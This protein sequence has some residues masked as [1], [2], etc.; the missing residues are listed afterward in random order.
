MPSM[1]DQKDTV[2]ELQPLSREIWDR[3]YRLRN[4]DGVPQEESVDETFIR[5][6][7]EIASVEKE[8]QRQKWEQSFLWAL[9]N[10]AVPAGRIL[11]NAGSLDA[12]SERNASLINC[13]VSQS[14]PDNLDGIL[15]MVKRAGLTLKAGSGIGY[16]FSTVRPA[17]SIVRGNNASAFGPLTVM[18]LLDCLCA[19]ISTAGDRRGAQMAV[20]DIRHPDILSFIE[21]KHRHGRFQNFNMSVLVTDDFLK[22]LENQAV[23]D[24]VF[25]VKPERFLELCE[26]S[27]EEGDDSLCWE[28]F[29]DTGDVVKN[30]TGL[31]ACEK[32]DAVP[33]EELWDKIMQSTY[34][35]SEPGILFIDR[36][37]ARNNNSFCETI[38]ATNPCGE[39]PLPPD[40]ACLLGS[41][42]LVHFIEEPFT[43]S[44]AF[45]WDRFEQVVRIFVRLLDNVVDLSNLPLDAQAEEIFRKRRHGM[46][47]LGLGSAV[48]MLRMH[49]G[50]KHSL[51]FT[52]EVLRRMAL[53]GWQQAVEI[54]RE[55]GP[56]PIM[57]E[58]F[59]LDTEMLR[60]APRLQSRGLRTGDKVPG[61]VLFANTQ[62]HLSDLEQLDPE[63]LPQIEK[64]GARF[65][66]HTSIAPTG[67]IALSIGNN[68]SNGIEPS[69]EHRYTRRVLD[70]SLANR[71][72]HT[73]YSYEYL[74]FR[75][76]LGLSDMVAGDVP[77]W[78]ATAN[79]V[80]YQDHL[81]VQAAAQKWVDS[82]I[83]KTVNL[84]PDIRFDE[85]KQLYLDA[86][87]M[88]LNGCT[89]FRPNPAAYDSILE[90]AE[91]SQQQ[92]TLFEFTMDDHSRLSV[93]GET[94]VSYNGINQSAEDLF[95]ALEEHSHA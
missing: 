9:R 23:W 60:R 53:V 85:F 56:A 32:Y 4:L 2:L 31:V 40:G 93:P 44:A 41:V 49:Y 48:A 26:I 5:V 65:T 94:R 8:E 86:A 78:F 68:V 66:H 24:L 87:K 64:Y 75:Q 21:A 90:R 39:Q 73:V 33:A 82:S 13:V 36:I 30:E 37:N 29:P 76:K 74:L 67:T 51:A 83:S 47:I 63:I 6:A 61:R 19:G 62:S 72:E 34:E 50:D 16:D 15:T 35:F 92:Q 89:T 95:R 79:S 27:G 59:T 17:G 42:N 88:G 70:A 1:I 69:F 91:P 80:S 22:A 11:T 38:R 54:A 84:D 46:G 81:A 77:S 71:E 52:E 43:A 45:Q 20:M 7:R 14:I 58:T 55:K 28:D 10:C 25:P 3:K 57:E 18:E 12:H